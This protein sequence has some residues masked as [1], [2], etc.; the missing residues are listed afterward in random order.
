[1]DTKLINA[2]VADFGLDLLRFHDELRL[3]T[4]VAPA[5]C[6]ANQAADFEEVKKIYTEASKTEIGRIV[7]EGSAKKM[8]ERIQEKIFSN[9]PDE[10]HFVSGAFEM[11]L[12][13]HGITIPPSDSKDAK[14]LMA[15]LA[16]AAKLAHIIEQERVHGIRDESE[17]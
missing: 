6:D 15:A 10:L 4:M 16:Q 17:Q 2:V 1:M 9:S 5:H 3:G 14:E 8:V 11:F 13:K 12:E 7:L